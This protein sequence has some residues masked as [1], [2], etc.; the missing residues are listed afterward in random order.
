MNI[1]YAI[2]IKCAGYCMFAGAVPHY[3]LV[4]KIL[5]VLN[6]LLL[7]AAVVMGIYC[8]QKKNVLKKIMLIC[9]LFSVVSEYRLKGTE[10][11]NPALVVTS[12]EKSPLLLWI[13]LMLLVLNCSGGRGRNPQVPQSAIAPLLAEMNFY[14]NSS[15]IIK[16]RLEAEETAA[17]QRAGGA[18]VRLEVKQQKAIT[19]NIMKEIGVLRAKKRNLQSN[20]GGLGRIL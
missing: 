20:T 17:K 7:T 19:D 9:H 14:R 13:L 2:M 5:V 8:K 11:D 10:V 3:L 15:H 4:I 18:Q 12:V 6:F 1:K 16:A